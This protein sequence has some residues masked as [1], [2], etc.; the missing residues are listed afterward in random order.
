MMWVHMHPKALKVPSKIHNTFNGLLV[1][2]VGL[3]FM[4]EK[5]GKCIIY[6][7]L[8]IKTLFQ[9]KRPKSNKQSQDLLSIYDSP[10]TL[11]NLI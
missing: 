5:R 4:E 10:G 7:F 6:A 3:I 8:D 11:E 9:I 2:S 1:L